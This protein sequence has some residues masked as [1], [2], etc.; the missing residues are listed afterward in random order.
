MIACTNSLMYLSSNGKFAF[1]ETRKKS[2][3]KANITNRNVF[4]KKDLSLYHLATARSMLFVCEPS[5]GIVP[6]PT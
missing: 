4:I 3:A 1:N 5:V 6:T 2:F